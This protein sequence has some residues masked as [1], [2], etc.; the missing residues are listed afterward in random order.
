MDDAEC[1]AGVAVLA[2][3][4]VMKISVVVNK[5]LSMK[6]SYKGGAT[7]FSEAAA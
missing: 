7:I 5:V 4:Y 1:D 2:V 3:L 6:K